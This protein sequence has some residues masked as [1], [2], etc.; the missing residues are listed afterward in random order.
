MDLRDR[1]PRL[2]AL[3]LALALGGAANAPG[4]PAVPSPRVAEDTV[5]AWRIAGRG[6]NAHAAR[7]T[8]VKHAGAASAHVVASAPNPGMSGGGDDG[9]RG[10]RGGGRG[11][12][13]PRVRPVYFEQALNAVPY[14]ERRVRVSLWVR[15][16][17][18]DKPA[19]DMPT[20]QAHAFIRVDNE[21]ASTSSY[22]GSTISP[23]FG[24]TDWTRKVMIIEVPPDAFALSFGVGM[25][26]PGELWVDDVVIDDQGAASGAYARQPMFTP[27][28]LQRATPEQVA[29]GKEMIARRVAAAKERPTEMTNG[30]FEMK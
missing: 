27:E 2:L 21:D 6:S 22:D 8:T 19:K 7:D 16:R 25:L 23:I 24:T 15:T 11:P 14:R 17:L 30:D 26:G 13:G 1:L 12:Q 28:Q 20:S 5:V 10:G 29:Q 4:S 9:G 3:P 18:P